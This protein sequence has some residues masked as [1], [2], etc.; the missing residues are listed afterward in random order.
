MQDTAK[1][2]RDVETV[3]MA[4]MGC[5]VFKEEDGSSIYDIYMFNNNLVVLIVD[6]ME[7]FFWYKMHV[8]S[9]QVLADEAKRLSE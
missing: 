1:T 7:S 3:T 9:T 6:A 2:N 5:C 4:T 8:E